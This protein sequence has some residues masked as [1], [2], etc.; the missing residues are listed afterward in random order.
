MCSCKIRGRR[1]AVGQCTR[2]TGRIGLLRLFRRRKRGFEGESVGF[3]PGEES[4]LAEESGVGVLG[5]VDVS[6]YAFKL[7]SE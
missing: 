4:S 3:K 7:L 6:V 5:G 2:D 1:C